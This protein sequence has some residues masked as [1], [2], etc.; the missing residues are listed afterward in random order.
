MMKSAVICACV[1][2]CVA[3]F[4]TTARAANMQVLNPRTCYFP[5]SQ[6]SLPVSVVG[7]ED[8]MFNLLFT[9]S[10]KGT[11]VARRQIPFAVR[12]GQTGRETIT[13]ELPEI[14]D[15]IALKGGYRLELVDARGKTIDVAESPL[16]VLDPDPFRYRQQWLTAQ[17]LHVYDPE[18]VTVARLA[19]SGIPFVQITNPDAFG[20]AAGGVLIIGEGL[21]LRRSR[22]V[23]GAALATVAK[24]TSVIVFAPS[25][26]EFV[27]PGVG[28]EASTAKDG[29]PRVI[30]FHGPEM[31]PALDKRL[32]D[33]NWGGAAGDNVL[34]YFEIGAHRDHPEVRVDAKQGWT[35][36]SLDW[37]HGQQ[38][39]FSGFAVMRDWDASPAPRYFF[40]ALLDEIQR[41]RGQAED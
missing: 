14:R 40:A 34:H 32:D 3:V 16:H 20:E 23:I 27:L 21:S 13:F 35:G 26:G 17:R 7:A 9:L 25:E 22:G 29:N 6:V 38:M 36:I 33:A 10:F 24:Q 5:G 39:F 37:A 31:I 30:R 28:G 8:G 11:V 41:S 19:S 15:G 12:Q 4:A 18:G 2:V 1:G